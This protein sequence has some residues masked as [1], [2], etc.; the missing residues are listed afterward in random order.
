MWLLLACQAPEAPLDPSLWIYDGTAEDPP[1]TPT[2]AEIEAGFAAAIPLLREADPRV[3]YEAFERWLAR[4]GPDCPHREEHN[5][6]DLTMGDCEDDQGRA[7]YGFQLTT[8]LRGVPVDYLGISGIHADFLWLTGTAQIAIDGASLESKGDIL[9]RDYIDD[10]D[11]LRHIYGFV[12]GNYV[13]P[14]GSGWM[15]EQQGMEMTTWA[16]QGS[17]GSWTLRYEGGISQLPG[18]FTALSADGLTLDQACPE[19]LSAGRL[20]IWDASR[21]WYWLEADGVCDGCAPLSI[22]GAPA[23]TACVDLSALWGWE[24]SSAGLPWDPP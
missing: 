15:V 14:Q 5:N 13:D 21:R 11:G 17:D 18:A 9:M 20:G 3:A 4:M 6:Q 7:Y 12:W 1:A 19:E 2:T 10:E 24:A 22:D 8:R 16:D 23:G